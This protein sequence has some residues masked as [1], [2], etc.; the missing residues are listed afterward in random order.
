MRSGRTLLISK[1]SFILDCRIGRGSRPKYHCDRSVV[2]VLHVC[3]SD[4]GLPVIC[5]FCA[6]QLPADAVYCA[7]CGR[8]AM[9]RSARR[10]ADAAPQRPK[11]AWSKRAEKKAQAAA[12]L[13][14]RRRLETETSETAETAETTQTVETSHA[15]AASSPTL[16]PSADVISDVTSAPRVHAASA[17]TAVQL[18]EPLVL[19]HAASDTGPSVRVA[20]SSESVEFAKSS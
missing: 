18:G 8:P 17:S 6:T 13:S 2:I 4:R 9:F 15:T 14:A 16:T 3:L 1:I 12:S 7:E 20:E 11:S 19:S 5:S 10:S